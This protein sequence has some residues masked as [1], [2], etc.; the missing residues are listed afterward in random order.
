MQTFSKPEKQLL[1]LPVPCLAVGYLGK[2]DS[3][4]V[5]SERSELIGYTGEDAVV[6]ARTTK[7]LRALLRMLG[8][9]E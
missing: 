8:A 6:K 5:Y 2:H 4:T 9:V 3:D 1:M 7:N